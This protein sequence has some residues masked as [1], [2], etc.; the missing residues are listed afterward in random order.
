VFENLPKKVYLREVGPRDGLQNEKQFVPTEKKKEFIRK[1]AATGLPHI[2]ITSFVHPKWIPA[3]TDSAE[4]GK[5]F[6]DMGRTHTSA[7]VPNMK[8]LEGAEAAGMKE[9]AVFMSATESHNKANLNRSIKESLAQMRELIPTIKAKGMKVIGSVSV[10]FGCPF[11]GEVKAEQVTPIVKEM[12]A[13][14]ADYISLGDTIGVGTPTQTRRLLER[15]LPLVEAKRIGM[16][17]HNTQGTALANALASLQMG[18]TTFD[19][20]VG[21]LGG[22]PYAPGASGNVPTEDLVYLFE[23]MGIATGVNLEALL[24]VGVWIE[25]E[26]G[27][28]L[29]SAGLKAYQGRKARAAAQAMRQA[30]G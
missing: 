25:H 15:L 18:I 24:E 20:S 3:L 26:L 7:L 28:P 22:C 8:G 23:G 29:A 10:V 30:A 16:H 1:L 14:G 27:H 17:F 21:G 13:Y 2:E 12:L 19:G 5:T 9:V 4:I 11:E 6:A